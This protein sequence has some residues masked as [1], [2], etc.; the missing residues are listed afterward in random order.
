MVDKKCNVVPKTLLI[1]KLE[2][3]KFVDS[4][5]RAKTKPPSISVWS[6]RRVDYMRLYIKSKIIK[7]IQSHVHKT[8]HRCNI[9][10][11]MQS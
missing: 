1:E 4:F 3:N 11:S 9:C 8:L 6:N 7:N 10:K 2:S 5:V